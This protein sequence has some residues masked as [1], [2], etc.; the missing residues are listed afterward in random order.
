MDD[1]GNCSGDDWKWRVLSREMD[2]ATV[3]RI[4]T[5]TTRKRRSGKKKRD[6]VIRDNR[7]SRR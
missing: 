3:S 2:S 5:I 7:R 1:H 4:A 6:E